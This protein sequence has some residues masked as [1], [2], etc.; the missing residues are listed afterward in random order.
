MRPTTPNTLNSTGTTLD[1][2]RAATFTDTAA[3]TVYYWTPDVIRE[4]VEEVVH[5]PVI[6]IGVVLGCLVKILLTLGVAYKIL[7]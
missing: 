5:T 6:V 1:T 4:N 3:T 7:N 2:A